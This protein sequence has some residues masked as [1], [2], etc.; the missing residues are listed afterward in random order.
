MSQKAPEA[1]HERR[2]T[3]TP[4]LIQLAK[5]RNGGF[6]RAQLTILGVAWPPPRGWR[7]AIVGRR[8][9]Q[10]ELESFWAGGVGNARGDCG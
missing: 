2:V 6:T 1:N 7:R 8:I 9:S 3:L 10:S 5:T 4:D